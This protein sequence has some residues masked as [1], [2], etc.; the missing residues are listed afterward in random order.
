MKRPVKGKI[1]ARGDLSLEDAIA[2][3]I[4]FFF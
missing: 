1:M 2:K 3:M 4:I